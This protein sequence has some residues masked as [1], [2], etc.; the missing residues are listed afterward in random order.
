MQIY[1]DSIQLFLSMCKSS[2]SIEDLQKLY[3]TYLSTAWNQHS[4]GEIE[5]LESVQMFA[6]QFCCKSLTTSFE[7]CIHFG[8]VK[9]VHSKSSEKHEPRLILRVALNKSWHRLI[10]DTLVVRM[11]PTV[12]IW[13]CPSSGNFGFI[14]ILMSHFKIRQ[15][16]DCPDRNKP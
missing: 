8:A 5:A 16:Q 11:L 2:T 1:W 12:S 3:Q 15:K 14:N 6:F 7:M 10:W 4:S 9:V 13:M